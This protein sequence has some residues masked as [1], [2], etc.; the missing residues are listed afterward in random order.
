MCGFPSRVA[1]FL[2]KVKDTVRTIDLYLQRDRTSMMSLRIGVW[3]LLPDGYSESE[4]IIR[5]GRRLNRKN[6]LNRTRK[7]LPKEDT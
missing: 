3:Y 5:N 4:R 2:R 6:E 7:D 1:R